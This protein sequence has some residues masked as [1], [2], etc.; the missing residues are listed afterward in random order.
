MLSG[1]VFGQRSS[2]NARG[3]LSVPNTQ[4]Q[5]TREHQ[6]QMSLA[7]QYAE[8]AFQSR[9]SQTVWA[10]KPGHSKMLGILLSPFQCIH[11]RLTSLQT[12]PL[13]YS[14]QAWYWPIYSPHLTAKL[15]NRSTCKPPMIS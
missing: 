4:P 2:S 3:L 11:K 15:K 5:C 6:H 9:L 14:Y 7:H 8:R 10:R 13:T 12:K 1:K